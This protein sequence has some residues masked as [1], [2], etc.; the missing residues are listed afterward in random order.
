MARMLHW[1]G[2]AGEFLEFALLLVLP[3]PPARP[4]PPGPPSFRPI[5]APQSVK[6][7]EN[8]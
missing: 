3:D 4:A 7:L 6:G 8:L 2:N 1:Q 5:V